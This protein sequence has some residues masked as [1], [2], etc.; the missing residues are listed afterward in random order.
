MLFVLAVIRKG[1]FAMYDYGVWKN[2]MNY[3]Q[4][5]PPVF[6]LGSIPSSLPMWMGYGGNDALADVLDVQHT[7]KE[8][9]S[10]PVLVYHE[11]YGH[12]DFLLSVTAKEDVYD[13][14]LAFFRSLGLAA[15]YWHTPV[16][17]IYICIVLY[18]FVLTTGKVY[19]YDHRCIVQSI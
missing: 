16:L 17:Y 9:A 11:N 12:I 18:C 13:S 5:K 3:R 4:L 6:D 1:S 7:L 19:K 14:M 10:K 2:L 8:L 15:S